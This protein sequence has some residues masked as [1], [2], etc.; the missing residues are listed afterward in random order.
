MLKTFGKAKN[1][2]SPLIGVATRSEIPFFDRQSYISIDKNHGFGYLA[3]IRDAS[4]SVPFLSPS[5]LLDNKNSINTIQDGDILRLRKDGVIEFLWKKGSASNC[6]FV[7]SRCN[8]ECLMCPQPPTNDS[9][10]FDAVITRVL[11]LLDKDGEESVCITGGEPTLPRERFL[12]YLSML[13]LDHNNRRVDVLTNGQTFSDLDFT[14]HVASECPDKTTFCTSLH[15]DTASIHNH[16]VSSSVAFRKTVYGIQNLAR[17]G[18]PIE[19]RFVLTRHNARR[20]VPFAEFVVKNFPFVFH[21]ALMS[22]EIV[23]LAAD[24]FED[25]WIDPVECNDN[26]SEA[27]KVLSRAGISA[28]I[29]NTPLCLL[30]E[31]LWKYCRQSISDWKNS[32]IELCTPCKLR[33]RCCGI[34]STSTRLSQNLRPK[35]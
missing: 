20:M 30:D 16:I 32:F 25:V 31:S 26:F 3:H 34:F 1:I 6:L 33:D 22:L 27:I 17:F 19:I 35:L 21:V 18:L 10:D 2:R 23:G 13:R 11:S 12:K 14:S 5:I 8:C 9:E 29:Y 4:S 28:S 7:T 15:A 24:N